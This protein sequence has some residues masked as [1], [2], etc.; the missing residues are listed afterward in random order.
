MGIKSF[1]KN[2]IVVI[3]SIFFVLILFVLIQSTL[4]INHSNMRKDIMFSLDGITKPYGKGNP[5]IKQKFDS[6]QTIFYYLLTMNNPGK[7]WQGYLCAQGENEYH[8]FAITAPAQQNTKI[9]LSSTERFTK[10]AVIDRFERTVCNID[11]YPKKKAL[12]IGILGNSSKI[13]TDYAFP[14]ENNE[15]YTH[16]YPIKTLNLREEELTQILPALTYLLIDNMNTEDLSCKSLDAIENWVREGGLLIFGGGGLATQN[17]SGF[18]NF[19]ED[20]DILVYLHPDK[21]LNPEFSQYYDYKN[22]PFALI[23]RTDSF[24]NNNSALYASFKHQAG[25]CAMTH[26]SPTEVVAQIGID[27]HSEEY[28]NFL[29][30][31]N[32]ILYSLYYNYNY[33]G[34]PAL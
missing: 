13:L 33:N 11:F 19:F 29:S 4:V 32:A 34:T 12:C 21:Q 9:L 15:Y 5:H 30:N 23:T 7:S 17:F 10:V 3:V 8:E 31:M 14:A 24:T 22:V 20:A 25:A 18:D 28:E 26:F 6:E 16:F 1:T 27:N 2:N